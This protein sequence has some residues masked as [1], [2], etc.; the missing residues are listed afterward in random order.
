[1][2]KQFT[3][4]GGQTLS[5]SE[6]AEFA[7]QYEGVNMAELMGADP[8]NFPF[9][10]CHAEGSPT[11]MIWNKPRGMVAHV[12]EDPVRH[13]ATVAY[14]REHAYPEFRSIG[15]AEAYARE[16]DWPLEPL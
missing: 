3:T 5:L 11:I 4:Y 14:L 10:I 9:L 7:R 15:E 8:N 12:D 6:V 1:M 13:H 2:K 16:H